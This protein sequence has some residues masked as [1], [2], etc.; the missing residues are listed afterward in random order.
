MSVSFK[1]FEIDIKT[2]PNLFLINR[3]TDSL[4]NWLAKWGGLLDGLNFI[5]KNL[6]ATYSG[7]F[8]N[9]MLVSELVRIVP[10]EE[11]EQENQMKFIHKYGDF[12]DDIRRKNL[13]STLL[14]EFN[15]DQN[16]VPYGFL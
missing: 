10:S 4:L 11:N 9:S 3:N 13:L 5:G 7:Y 8:L 6:L 16:F 1:Y 2:D 12:K 15:K 14:E